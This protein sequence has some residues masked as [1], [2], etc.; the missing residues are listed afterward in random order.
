MDGGRDWEK[1]LGGAGAKGDRVGGSDVVMDPK[2]PQVVYASLW[3]DTLGPWEDGYQYA[4]TGGGLFKSTDSG[5]TWKQLKN[6]LPDNLVQINVAV[7]ASDPQRLYATLSTM[8]ESGYGRATGLGVYRSDDA[9]ETWRKMTE[10][11][12]PAMKVGGG[13]LPVAAGCRQKSSMVCA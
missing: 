11:P 6:G 2:N 10:D 4:G 13:G 5:T 3:E 9:G 7:A 1:V 8:T 12:R